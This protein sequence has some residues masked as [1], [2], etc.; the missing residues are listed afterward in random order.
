M[1]AAERYDAPLPFW[2]AAMTRAMALAYTG[3]SE[4]QMREWERRGVVRFCTRGP[5]GSAIA[6]TADLKA[7]VDQLFTGAAVDDGPIEF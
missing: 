5:N 1:S 7:A 2:P 3:V 6:R 4:T